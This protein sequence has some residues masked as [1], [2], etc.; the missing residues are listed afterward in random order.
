MAVNERDAVGEVPGLIVGKVGVA[1]AG[2]PAE[3]VGAGPPQASDTRLSEMPRATRRTCLF[4][5]LRLTLAS[6]KLPDCRSV[7]AGSGTGAA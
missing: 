3:T 6:R 5:G 1:V 4:R 2:G 7:D